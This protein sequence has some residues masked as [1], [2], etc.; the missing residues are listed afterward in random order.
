MSGLSEK[1]FKRAISETLRSELRKKPQVGIFQAC[2]VSGGAQVLIKFVYS[3]GSWRFYG[4]DGTQV[5]EGVYF[6]ACTWA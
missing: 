3:D 1:E 5:E 4:P 6:E 2:E